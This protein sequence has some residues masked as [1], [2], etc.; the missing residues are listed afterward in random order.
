[1]I[2]ID[3]KLICILPALDPFCFSSFDIVHIADCYGGKREFIKSNWLGAQRNNDGR[4]VPFLIEIIDIIRSHSQRG[5]ERDYPEYST[6][7]A[8]NTLEYFSVLEFCA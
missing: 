5:G 3:N 2:I 7:S 4:S 6:T 8:F 1:M